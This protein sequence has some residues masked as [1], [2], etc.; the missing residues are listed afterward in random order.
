MYRCY[1]RRCSFLQ[2]TLLKFPSDPRGEGPEETKLKKQAENLGLSDLIDFRGVIPNAELP[3]ILS[4]HDVL[5]LPS[6][7]DGWGA[8]VN[9]ALHTGLFAIA[10]DVCGA[11]V[12]FEDHHACASVLGATFKRRNVRSLATV[13]NAVTPS[14]ISHDARCLRE[15]WAMENIS[16]KVMAKYFCD[17]IDHRINGIKPTVAP[18]DWTQFSIRGK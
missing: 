2:S 17:S 4:E 10:S 9:E 18:P 5:V 6:Q 3:P 11:S 16:P 15:N 7:Y 1:F 14:E 13:L 8:V 12:L